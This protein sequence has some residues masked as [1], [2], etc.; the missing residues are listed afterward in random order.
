MQRAADAQHAVPVPSREMRGIQVARPALLDLRL[1]AV[2]SMP[3][4]L[5]LVSV[6]L[7]LRGTLTLALSAVSAAQG[8]VEMQRLGRLDAALAAPVHSRLTQE[9]VSAHLVL[10]VQ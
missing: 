10:R 9:T 7:M 6:E 2:S 1:L 3:L 5:V 4:T 8:T